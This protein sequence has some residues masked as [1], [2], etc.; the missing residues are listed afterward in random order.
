MLL[1]AMVMYSLLQK[2]LTL[3]NSDKMY[4]TSTKQTPVHC[5]AQGGNTAMVQLLIDKG[6]SATDA[7]TD[8]NTALRLCLQGL[9]DDAKCFTVLTQAGADAL[10]I[11]EDTR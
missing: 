1:L 9:K 2:G 6:C 11:N 10:D 3:P 5:A 7:D 8:G 4:Y